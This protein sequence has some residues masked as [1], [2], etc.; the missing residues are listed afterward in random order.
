MDQRLGS[1]YML[2]ERLGRG[3]M[4]TVWRAVN[5]DTGQP[6]A[7]KVLSEEFS[8]EPDMV[9]R[10]IQERN[11]LIGVTHPNLVRIHDLVVE[12][13]RLAIVMDL[14]NG[15]DLHR[16]LAERG[17]LSVAEAAVIG[18]GVADALSAIHAAGIIHR[19]LKPANIL[20]DIGGPQPIPKLVD[21]GIARM[22]AG[23]RLTSRSSV[24]GTPQYLSPEAISG[25]EPSPALDVYALGIALYELLTGKPP[26]YG[27]QLL[28]VL[29]Q[30]MYQEPPWPASIPPQILPLLQAML[31]KNPQARPTAADLSR[32]LDA[33]S[34]GGP[35]VFPNVAPIVPVQA[36]PPT[37]QPQQPPQQPQ[38]WQS[39]VPGAAIVPVP[40]Q[41]P[42][43][44]APLPQQPP[45]GFGPGSP[46]PGTPLPGGYGAPPQSPIPAPSPS[47]FFYPNPDMFDPNSPAASY[48]PSPAPFTEDMFQPR[49]SKRNTK[50]LALLGGGGVAVVAVV[51]V[52]LALTLGGGKS[53][54]PS[55][56]ST[57]TGGTST[58][59]AV[60]ACPADSAAVTAAARWTLAGTL[61][62]CTQS[63]S[64]TDALTLAKGASFSTSGSRGK[65]LRV[66]GDTG[67]A[68]VSNAD[69]V[70]TSKSFTVSVWVDYTTFDK[71]AYTTVLAF[72][73]QLLDSF[74][75]E[76]N[77]GS[78]GWTFNHTS[79]DS[80][81]AKYS[82]AA[83]KTAPKANSWTHLVG[84]Y[85]AD[86]KTM[87]L[88]VNGAQVAQRT[89]V[90]AWNAKNEITL[91]ADVNQSGSVAAAME[92]E[93]SDLQ[94]FQKALTVNQVA[95]IS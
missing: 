62:D 8:D 14:V 11:T 95:S 69:I 57:G 52:V 31:A 94:V 50:K 83:S 79:E 36:P 37:P 25:I 90:A 10:F 43:P 4:G 9:T 23:S 53:P 60:P 45:M 5:T 29:N 73:G 84:V 40:P 92:G 80:A 59:A 51:G 20:L 27:E 63:P 81:G 35:T 64:H 44:Q 34:Q 74:A 26:F 21:F 93:L 33:L 78:K 70:N 66:N 16:H 71:T 61:G 49:K 3:A 42:L 72:H 89:G 30:H 65:V 32:A 86:A 68:T 24:V 15:P 76:Y 38:A 13:G 56:I 39:P 2:K 88:Y 47:G 82:S 12:D 85:D 22:V 7:V 28:Q 67:V 77:P 54:A 58:L 41:S 87:T 1:R 75:I 48:N 18:R 6:V 19:D 55:P 17:V 91:G 46:N